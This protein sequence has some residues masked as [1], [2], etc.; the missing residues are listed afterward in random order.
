MNQHQTDKWKDILENSDNSDN[1]KNLSYDNIIFPT[2]IKVSTK[3][4]ANELIFATK[5]EIKE[6]EDKVKIENRNNKIDSIVEG[7]KYV[8]KKI[9]DDKEYKKLMKKGV[10]PMKKPSSVIYYIDTIYKG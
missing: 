9:E 4:I 10:T 2:I 7:K 8:E 1:S 5:E 6:I 3:T